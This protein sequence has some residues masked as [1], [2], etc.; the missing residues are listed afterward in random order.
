M[1]NKP[2]GVVTTA[3][4]ERGRQTVYDLLPEGIPFVAPVGRLDMASEGLLLFTNDSEWGASIAAPATHLDKTYHVQISAIPSRELSDRLQ[5]G[6]I[7]RG[8]KLTVKSV[9]PLRLGVRN[10]W[11]E[12]VLDEGRNRHIRRILDELQIEVLRLVRVAIGPLYLGELVKGTTRPLTSS[13]KAAIRHA[14]PAAPSS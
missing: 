14:L 3:S 11:L 12:I 5:A 7:S 13:E 10:G 6:V 9:Q 2:R 8:E 1:M 4:D